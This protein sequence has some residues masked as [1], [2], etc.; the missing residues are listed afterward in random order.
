MTTQ[1]KRMK[2]HAK[3]LVS[4]QRSFIESLIA[5]RSTSGMTQQDVANL[6]GVSQSAVSLF[7]HYDSNPTL[8]SIRRYA[9]A[10]NADLVMQVKPRRTYT[11]QAV[12]RDV[13]VM[14]PRSVTRSTDIRWEKSESKTLE[15][16]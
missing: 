16:A 5:L 6:M 8:A 10:V 4:T 12:V 9:L 7:E 14:R 11:T 13:N 15:N 1:K 3:E 2:E